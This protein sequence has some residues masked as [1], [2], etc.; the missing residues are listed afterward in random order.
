RRRR[1]TPQTFF[2]AC[3]TKL[4]MKPLKTAKP[5]VHKSIL[6]PFANRL[7]RETL[8]MGG[9]LTVLMSIPVNE[10]LEFS[11][12]LNRI[13]KQIINALGENHNLVDNRESHIVLNVEP[14]AELPEMG[15]LSM[16]IQP[17]P[18]SASEHDFIL[19]I[20][21]LKYF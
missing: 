10:A 20:T 13:P 15:D 11:E 8:N 14:S 21:D 12:L 9:Q 3:L 7:D 16:F 17:F 18:I 1:I 5:K 6:I 2:M 19:N 4:L